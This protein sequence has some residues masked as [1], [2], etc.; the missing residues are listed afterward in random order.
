KYYFYDN[1]FDLPSA[2]LCAK[3]VDCIEM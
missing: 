1:H 2:L 3:I